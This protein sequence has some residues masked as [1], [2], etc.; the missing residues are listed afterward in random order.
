MTGNRD[1]TTSI[2]GRFAARVGDIAAER[3]RPLARAKKRA[4]P[5]DRHGT[6]AIGSAAFRRIC[7]INEDG[8]YYFV[9]DRNDESVAA[10]LQELGDLWDLPRPQRRVAMTL[11]QIAQMNGVNVADG[12]P[13]TPG[14]R[15][16]LQAIG[17]AM[18]LNASDLKLIIRSDHA[19]LRLRLGAEEYTHGPHWQ[20]GEAEDAIA[21]LYDSR[22]YG[23]GAAS[24]QSGQHQPFS[25][26]QERRIALPEGLSALR[27]QKAPHGD[28]HDFVVLRLLRSAEADAAGRIEDL[29]LDDDVLDALAR[30]RTSDNGLVIIGG[31]TGDGKSTTLVRQ[32]ERLYQERDGRVSIMTVEDPIE[33][34]IQGDGIIQMPVEGAAEG[35]ARGAAYTRVLKTFVR[36]NPDVGMVSEIRDADNCREVMQ[37]V[38]SGHKVFTTIHSFSANAVLFRLVSLGVD[39]RELAE[40]GVISLVM[41]QK[42]VP[43][44]CPACSRPAGDADRRAIEEW[45][46]IAATGPMIRDRNGCAECLKGKDG[47]TAREAW[48]GLSRKRATAEFIELDDRYRRFV[49]D[50]D[51]HGALS[52]WLAPRAEG[53][54]GGV[55]VETRL[56]RLVAGGLADFEDVTR[57]KLPSTLTAIEEAAA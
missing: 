3:L 20:V 24:Q 2:Q 48:A 10:E 56:Q 31:S 32:L 43:I 19:V 38:I 34:P 36:S 54:L 21:W 33:Y 25:L 4:P 53:G 40:P 28:G 50:R 52:H 16:M 55:A 11:S 35:D 29:G 47:L 51:S 7:A 18:K 22:D 1:A 49:E 12:D 15:R 45:T 17:E 5:Q 44:L 42:L 8:T 57:R 23:D 14:A 9:P 46:R 41:R 39:P 26:G 27:G 37:F 6:L 13:P 30:E